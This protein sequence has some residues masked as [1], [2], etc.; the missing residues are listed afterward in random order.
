MHADA[1]ETLSTQSGRLSAYNNIRLLVGARQL[2]PAMVYERS[3][4][5]ISN[6]MP[7]SEDSHETQNTGNSPTA[8]A[9]RNTS[10]LNSFVSLLEAQSE[11]LAPRVSNNL[12]EIATPRNNPRS[13]SMALIP[14]KLED[15]HKGTHLLK[16]SAKVA[17]LNASDDTSRAL[18]RRILWSS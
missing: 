12:T 7:Y 9:S 17:F 5:L 18:C 8:T 10:N 6:A 14:K 2:S 13:P 15:H 3:M 11:S 1:A 16:K 4:H